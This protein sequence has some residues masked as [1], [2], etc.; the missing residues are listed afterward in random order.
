MEED[1]ISFVWQSSW[2][3]YHSD[4]YW[5]NNLQLNNHRQKGAV[6]SE[7]GICNYIQYEA[8]KVSSWGNGATWK[9]IAILSLWKDS[10][11]PLKWQCGWGPYRQTKVIV[12]LYVCGRKGVK[13]NL[14]PDRSEPHLETCRVWK[15][16]IEPPHP[17]GL[18]VDS[19]LPL[20]IVG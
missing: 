9:W 12:T 15:W 1:K 4:Y 11:I 16:T 7:K 14:H 2:G 5:Q 3:F 6:L 13:R 8:I 17:E 19:Q 10:K 18:T 20:H